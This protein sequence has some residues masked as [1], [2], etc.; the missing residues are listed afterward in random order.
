MFSSGISRSVH[1][2]GV[3]SSTESHRLLL[4]QGRIKLMPFPPSLPL[5]PL[6]I[7][8]G[9]DGLLERQQGNSA[10][11]APDRPQC[12]RNCSRVC[13]CNEVKRLRL[14]QWSW[15]DGAAVQWNI[16]VV[17]PPKKLAAKWGG[18]CRLPQTK[19]MRLST[20]NSP[21]R[22]ASD[23]GALWVAVVHF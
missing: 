13:C 8:C 21:C 9:L 10:W 2:I 11:F 15:T 22:R 16:S 19:G 3:L 1:T 14:K 18:L 17:G 7:W 20:R 4:H 23:K 5:W 12:W 6:S